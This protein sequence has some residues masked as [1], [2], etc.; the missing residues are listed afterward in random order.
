VCVTPNWVR[1][2][3]WRSYVIRDVPRSNGSEQH[4]LY[5]TFWEEIRHIQNSVL[6]MF[7][8]KNTESIKE[9]HNV[10]NIVLKNQ[11]HQILYKICGIIVGLFFISVSS[12]EHQRFQKRYDI[13]R[14]L[15]VISVSNQKHKNTRDCTRY[16]E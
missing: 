2:S 11:E 16:L 8:I 4:G 14:T 3:A 15:L 13:S 5:V 6:N 10:Y 1:V 7:Q 12:Q 9:L